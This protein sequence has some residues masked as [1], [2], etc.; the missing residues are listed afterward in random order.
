[1]TET[2]L[3]AVVV[4]FDRRD[5]LA[6]TLRRLLESDPVDLAGILVVDNAS[7]DGTGAWLAGL[8]DP[9]LRVLTLSRNQGGAGGFEA[10]LRHVIEKTDARWVCLMDDDARP[11]AGAFA[12]FRARRREDRAAWFAAVTYPDGAICEMNR[13]LL[14]P[15]GS[16]R[17]TIAAL[18]RGRE[19][20]HLSPDA[21]RAS[22]PVDI[23]GG[24]FVGAFLS[25]RAVEVAGYPD[26]RFFIYG[27]DTTYTLRLG[28]L[29]GPLGFDPAIRFEHDCGTT[30]AGTPVRPLWKVFYLYR[31]RAM[32]YRQTV[33]RALGTAI[34]LGLGAVWRLRAG[35]YGTDRAAYLRLWRA[36]M[37]DGLAGRLDRDFD[38]VRA[39]ISG[40]GP[41]R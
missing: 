40:S 19:T 26:G 4:T 34:Y 9:R 13:P 35:R 36:A 8:K 38:A 12:R 29:A 17:S 33:G 7:T 21:F 23:D 30:I 27:D 14:D 3:W 20:F 32:V 10:G 31:N 6:V 41:G 5:Q 2:R 24:S 25:R 11:V 28:R 16:A 22:D 15:F 1:M 18:I 37:S 39:L